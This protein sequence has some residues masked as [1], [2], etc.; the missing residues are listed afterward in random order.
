VHNDNTFLFSDQKSTDN[1]SRYSE[2]SQN[3]SASLFGKSIELLR[4]RCTKRNKTLEDVQSL[5]HSHLKTKIN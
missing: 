4:L 1:K 3:N 2:V 5:L